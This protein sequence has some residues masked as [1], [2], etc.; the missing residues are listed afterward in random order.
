MADPILTAIANHALALEAM[1]AGLELRNSFE[2]DDPRWIKNEKN[3]SGLFDFEAD[4][5]LELIS[6]EPTTLAGATKLIQYVSDLEARGHRWPD[7]LQDDEKPTKLRKDWAVLLHR[8]LATM[9]GAASAQ[10]G[11]P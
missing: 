9:T 3:V 7:G 11:A 10:Q 6:I 5:A 1:N 8:N 4:A 2:T